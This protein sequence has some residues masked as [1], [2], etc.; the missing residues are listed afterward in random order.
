MAWQLLVIVRVA[1][2]GTLLRNRLDFGCS[3]LQIC[4][5]VQS[6]SSGLGLRRLVVVGSR[7]ALSDH[8]EGAGHANCVEQTLSL[9]LTG[10]NVVQ[11]SSDMVLQAGHAE[12]LVTIV[13]L[14]RADLKTGF[15]DIVQVLGVAGRNGVI[16]AS[17]DFRVEA[18]HSGGAEGRHLG[19]HFV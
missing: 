2:H 4:G 15:Q 8:A 7:H 14:T 12:K 18:L 13:T 16:F 10:L 6:L 5:R 19:D 1:A 9:A 3:A 11:G 17:N